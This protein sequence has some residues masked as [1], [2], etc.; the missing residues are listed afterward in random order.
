MTL[1]GGGDAGRSDG[2]IPSELSLERWGGRLR[3]PI[4][5]LTRV[6][7]SLWIGTLAVSDP[8][9][10][11]ESGQERTRGGLAR[12]DLDTGA[13]E[14]WESQIPGGPVSTAG[15]VV[16]GARTIAVT[17][18]GLLVLDGTTITTHPLTRPDNTVLSPTHLVLDRPAT[19]EAR[20]WVSTDQGL[21]QLDPD[22]LV[23][24]STGNLEG[25]PTGAIALDP[26]TRDVYAVT[27]AEDG[28]SSVTRMQIAQSGVT[29]TYLPFTG[30]EGAH[31]GHVGDLVWSAARDAVLI[32]VASYD[33]AGPGILGWKSGEPTVIATEGEL[34]AAS[35][36]QA[37]SFGAATLAL[38]G[39]VLVV[40]GVMRARFGLS[41][42]GGGLAWIDLSK[43]DELSIVGIDTQNS[44]LS[45]EHIAALAYDPITHRTFT[46]LR[47]PCSEV[48][49]GNAGMDVVSFHA[50]KASVGRA[51]LSGVRDFASIGEVTTIAM[52]DDLPGLRC[53]GIGTQ[54]G[55]FEL[56]AGRFGEQAS[57]RATHGEG[58]LDVWRPTRVFP[59]A[60]A[61]RD[62]EHRIVASHRDSLYVGG[63]EGLLINP[64]IELGVNLRSTAAQWESDTVFWLAGPASHDP[65]D[66]PATA[67]AGPR[68]AARVQLDERGQVQS[69]IHFVGL[70]R[71][72]DTAVTGLPS[73]NVTDIVVGQA[74]TFLIAGIERMTDTTYDRQ[75]EAERF[76]DGQ[77]RS[78]G[79]ARIDR[80]GAITI[81]DDGTAVPDGRAAAL[82][83]EGTLWV[84][85]AQRG[86][87]RRTSNG[88][89][90]APL[91]GVQIPSGS[92][93]TDLRFGADWM[94]AT[95]STGAA[96]RLG[97]HTTFV[98][99]VGW[100]WA[101]IERA[102][103][104]LLIGADEGL[105]R[106]TAP[107][108][109]DPGE[110]AAVASEAPAFVTLR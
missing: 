71:E 48:R 64:A 33:V 18:E 66:P 52:R 85:D 91:S 94:V 37:Q 32:A 96:V 90:E 92:I 110:P 82:D 28:T 61:Y 27:Y 38:E 41:P 34:A 19:G 8:S 44:D 16:D 7:R 97:T 21:Y 11:A 87:L 81:L 36:G 6:G 63:A 78:G 40:G 68:G 108:A 58:E 107:G 76:I 106:V 95:Y 55:V 54:G 67:N 98:D 17:P 69:S 22:T 109:D 13:L 10:Y 3:G 57:M 49:L 86:L 56:H 93:P 35:H 72:G 84:L 23:V 102:A 43:R 42:E 62:A 77:D 51:V 25:A 26:A 29:T 24:R 60:L 14:V 31:A 83:S 15:V 4:Q 65:T 39:D 59:N 53:D 70:A 1:D 47:Q 74:E 30:Q 101:A 105:I 20:L 103:G 89:E 12:L 99:G 50:G 75:P 45:G 104:V 73:S 46:S 5:G 2:S 79:V 80:E 88:F 100:T 9:A